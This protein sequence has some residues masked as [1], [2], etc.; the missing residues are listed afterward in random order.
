M[1]MEVFNRSA[2][3]AY[4]H[5]AKRERLE[6]EDPEE[7]D[8]KPTPD[9]VVRGAMDQFLDTFKSIDWAELRNRTIPFIR[10]LR[11]VVLIGTGVVLFWILISFI[12]SASLW[13]HLLGKKLTY[14][15][16][17]E[18]APAFM[19]GMT[20]KIRSWSER[21]GRLDTPLEEF[22]VEE[23]GNVFF[24]PESR[25]TKNQ[26]LVRLRV[27]EWIQVVHD[28]KQHSASGI[29]LSHTIPLDH[30]SL[31]DAHIVLDKN[32]YLTDRR[33]PPSVRTG[34]VTPFLTPAF[35]SHRLRRGQK[36][37]ERVEWTDVFNDWKIHWAGTLQWTVGEL[38]A[39]SEGN[40][41]RLTYQA[42]VRPQLWA[43]PAWA[44]KAVQQIE[45]QISTEGVALFDAAH[46]RLT[47]NT[48]SYDGI[49][50]IPIRD[51]G[52]IPRELRVG[53]RVKNASGDI[54]IRFENKIDL[55]KN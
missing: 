27:K 31:S 55:H 38:E 17:S 15:F 52:R 7:L 12:F 18:G 41:I 9:P 45:P 1:C 54:V 53:R 22:Q 10:K 49:L 44:V 11:P 28:E 6:S 33:S 30:P 16:P 42:N 47:S 34:K 40:C 32:G 8:L 3:D 4:L 39:C 2:A 36:W 48:F 43:S 21:G 29:P 35:P 23:L 5:A 13:Y 20:D 19:V 37:T 25:A 14:A 46:R 26:T 24:E 51:L 50:R